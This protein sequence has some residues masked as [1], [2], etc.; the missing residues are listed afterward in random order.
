MLGVLSMAFDTILA[1]YVYILPGCATVPAWHPLTFGT[2][3]FASIF[4]PHILPHG[5]FNSLIGSSSIPAY[6]GSLHV[7]LIFRGPLCFSVK[8][9]K[10][11]IFF[12]KFLMKRLK[13]KDKNPTK[14]Y[15]S[16]FFMEYDLMECHS[17][18]SYCKLPEHRV[19]QDKY[20]PFYT[21]D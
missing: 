18:I 13:I 16:F 21:T 3:A 20:T 2:W 7:F 19:L 14:I 4:P 9:Y 10:D 1:K 17:H 11:I 8:T 5:I 12:C 15:L 6:S